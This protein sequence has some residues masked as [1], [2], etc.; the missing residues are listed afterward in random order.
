MFLA[1][2]TALKKKRKINQAKLL[3]GFKMAKLVFI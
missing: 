1:A 3:C 2:L